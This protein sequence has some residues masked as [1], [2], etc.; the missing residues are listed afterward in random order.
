MSVYAI[1]F[2]FA[3]LARS[4]HKKSDTMRGLSVMTIMADGRSDK[5]IGGEFSDLALTAAL[6][7]TVKTRFPA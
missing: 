4:D 7:T 5:C 3:L 6:E 2:G 1:T